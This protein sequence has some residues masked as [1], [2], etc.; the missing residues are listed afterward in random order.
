MLDENGNEIGENLIS[1]G[2][3]ELTKN[4]ETEKTE[5]TNIVNGEVWELDSITSGVITASKKIECYDEN[6]DCVYY[7]ALYKG[8]VLV[9][10]QSIKKTVVAGTGYEIFSLDVTV[11][12]NSGYKIKTF[13]WTDDMIPLS[14]SDS[15][16]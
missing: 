12:E 15:L 4:Y 3:F 10:V 13:M 1:D 9:K 6:M 2:G 16:S 7:V 5:F 14:S 11:P 8:D